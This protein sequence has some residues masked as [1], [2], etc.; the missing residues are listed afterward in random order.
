MTQCRPSNNQALSNYLSKYLLKQK[1]K[2]PWKSRMTQGYGLERVKAILR[3]RAAL[4]FAATNPEAMSRA[5][6]ISKETLMRLSAKQIALNDY[7]P[8]EYTQETLA[9]ERKSSPIEWARSAMN[10]T[11]SIPANIGTCS[12][13]EHD[14]NLL[15]IASI[16]ETTKQRA[17]AM[18]NSLLLEAQTH[19]ERTMT[20]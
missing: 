8:E 9:M 16:Y 20:T 5:L 11:L 4:E 18:R 6:M 3:S 19:I 7:R 17:D 1:G 13:R 15:K 10:S 14:S 12:R 2:L